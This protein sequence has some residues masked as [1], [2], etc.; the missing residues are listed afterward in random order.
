MTKDE[1]TFRI[2]NVGGNMPAF[3]GSLTQEELKEIVDFLI[4]MK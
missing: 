4:T 1:M 2:V 3:G